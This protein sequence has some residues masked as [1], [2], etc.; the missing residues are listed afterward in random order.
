MRKFSKN[1]LDRAREWQK[2]ID[3]KTIKIEL[4]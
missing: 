4:I 1:P 3:D 2:Q